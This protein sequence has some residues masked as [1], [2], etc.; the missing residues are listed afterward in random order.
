LC[1]TSLLTIFGH[2]FG[3]LHQVLI[4]ILLTISHYSL[5]AVLTSRGISDDPNP[6]HNLYCP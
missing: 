5:Y 1:Q 4:F 3:D 2:I 6:K